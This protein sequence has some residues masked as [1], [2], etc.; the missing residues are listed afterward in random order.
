ATEPTF[1]IVEVDTR[2]TEMNNVWWKYAWL[3]TL[4][5]QSSDF[6][7]LA[8]EIQ[9]LDEDGFVVD[10]DIALDLSLG[11]GETKTF[12]D[13]VLVDASVASSVDAINALVKV[14]EQ[15]PDPSFVPNS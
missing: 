14:R 5:N 12:R 15:I 7:V 13:Y 3:L 2:V 11:A 4:E 1:K 10:D 8:A 9:F 6:L